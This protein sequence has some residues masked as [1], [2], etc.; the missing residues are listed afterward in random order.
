MKTRIVALAGAVVLIVGCGLFSGHGG[1]TT[2]EGVTLLRHDP[3]DSWPAGILGG[4]VD[5][6]DGCVALVGKD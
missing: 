2:L 6:V 3:S 5:V 1:A 4:R